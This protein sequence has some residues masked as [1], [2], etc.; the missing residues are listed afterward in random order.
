MVDSHVSKTV[1]ASTTPRRVESRPP[2]PPT[3]FLWV[4]IQ[5]PKLQSKADVR[6]RHSF[7]KNRSNRLRKENDIQKLRAS[8]VPFPKQY[9][10]HAP[11]DSDFNSAQLREVDGGQNELML[12]QAP[13]TGIREAFP[14]FSI[15]ENVDIN[16]YFHHSLD[17]PAL[18]QVLLS[19][20]ASSRAAGLFLRGA[21]TQVV[22]KTAEDSFTLRIQ[23]LHSL[24]TMINDPRRM[25]KESAVMALTLLLCLEAIEGNVKAVIAHS[26][27]LCRIINLLGGLATLSHRALSVVFV[28][29]AM[30]RLN[31]GLPPA[32]QI[33][34]EWKQRVLSE[35]TISNHKSNPME[36]SAMGSGFLTSPWSPSLPSDL[37]LIIRSF[38]QLVLRHERNIALECHSMPIENDFL[39]LSVHELLS[40]PTKHRL[41]PF[42]DTVRLSLYLY[43]V[44]RIWSFC[45][46]PSMENLFRILWQSL[47][48][49]RSFI[50]ESSPDFLFWILFIGGAAT[51]ATESNA[52]VMR[53]LKDCADRLSV[54]EWDEALAVLK[55]FFFVPR[56][57]D[58]FG[59]DVWKEVQQMR[60]YGST[61]DS[62][63]FFHIKGGL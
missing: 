15:P 41:T 35:S 48:K 59:K 28:S 51:R 34:S 5:N 52:W 44:V 47:R 8:T 23:V 2:Q 40:L 21:P 31:T 26:N 4:D 46:K 24:Q 27:G 11:A 36:S 60:Q 58:E 57:R 20:S 16:L 7:I 12:Y 18:L 17:Q 55:G 49:C 43:S 30:T 39:V 14:S 9:L 33:S 38:Q 61:T 6:A 29:D 22:R 50:Q 1:P 56:T 3:N 54:F 13:E 32:F 45:G 25:Y 53:E 19:T 62:R 10:S 42:Q 37:Q 63:I